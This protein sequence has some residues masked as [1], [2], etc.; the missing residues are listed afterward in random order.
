MIIIMKV[1][2]IVLNTFS[3]NSMNLFLQVLDFYR[4]HKYSIV[5]EFL[6]M[7]GGGVSGSHEGLSS[8]APS[9]VPHYKYI[10]WLKTSKDH[11]HEEHAPSCIVCSDIP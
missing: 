9:W 11:D 7:K 1:V 5:K 8:A 2:R 4:V 3:W 10:E 6:K